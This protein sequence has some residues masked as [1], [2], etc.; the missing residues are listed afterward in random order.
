M[1]DS[2]FVSIPN[3]RDSETVPTLE[4]LVSGC[5]DPSRLRICVLSQGDEQDF[6]PV[7]AFAK[8]TKTKIKH[9]KVDALESRGVGWARAKLQSYYDG[10]DYYL[11]LDSHVQ[12]VRNWDILS[13]NDLTFAKS[14]TG[15]AV[16]TAYLP[17]YEIVSGKRIVPSPMATNFD[18]HIGPQGLVAAVYRTIPSGVFPERTY[19]YSGHYAFADGVF[20]EDV[21]YDP[22]IFFFGEEITQAVRAESAGYALHVPSR[23]VASHLYNRTESSGSYRRLMWDDDED[24]ER[25]FRWWQLDIMSRNKA[26]AICKGEWFGRFGITDL[27]LYKGYARSLQNL[28]GIDLKKVSL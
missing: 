3:Y 9:V 26:L 20:I 5:S 28:Y 19:F 7:D 23:H 21:P 24:V 11:Q 27:N 25:E 16:I 22:E 15:K 10:E 8:S 6:A 2:I 12:L 1:K 13:I 4:S 18:C 14:A 17:G